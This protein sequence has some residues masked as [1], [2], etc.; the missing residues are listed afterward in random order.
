MDI[1][2]FPKEE[3]FDHVF[4]TT[5]TA[6][7][8]QKIIVGFEIRATQHFH[9][10]KTSVWSF[11]QQHHV[12]M[13]KHNGPLSK[14]DIVTAG[15]AHMLHP[16]FRSHDNL[17]QQ[18]FHSCHPNLDSLPE[19]DD[20]HYDN[21]GMPDIFLSSGR[22]NG[23]CNGSTIRSNVLLIQ[24][25]RSQVKTVCLLLETTFCESDLFEYI[26]VSLKYDNPELFAKMLSLQNEFLDNHRNVAIAG[27]NIR[28]M[29]HT[30][31]YEPYSDESSLWTYLRHIPGVLHLDSCKRTA[32]IGKWNLS[33]TKQDYAQ[34]TEW[35]DEHIQIIFKNLPKDIQ[36]DSTTINF[37][38]PRR[39]S[40]SVRSPHA[41]SVSSGISFNQRL[42]ART[43][44][45]PAV[46]T[47]QRAAWSSPKP[48]S[49]LAYEFNDTEFPPMQNKQA[50]NRSTTV[51]TQMSS[52][53][54]Q[55]IKDSINAKTSKMITASKLHEEQ[56]D[57]HI[58]KIET[59]LASLTSSIVTQ[60]FAKL[61]GH[62]S[63]FVTVLMLDEKLGNLSRQIEKMSRVTSPPSSI[64]D[65]PP[66][67]KARAIGPAD[68]MDIVREPPELCS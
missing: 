12:F 24:V 4:Q 48:I 10:I 60:I 34:V 17:R 30:M 56:I 31:T 44:D 20:K 29:D 19:Y 46:I 6:G 50:N 53:S 66:P 28:A 15:W 25:E 27:L 38:I 39:L 14:M 49:A 26:P 33:T 22:L 7:R 16:T 51:A 23:N 63:P 62:D 65:S 42:A 55:M 64:T 9:A 18:I 36:A 67:Q 54:E 21:K 68:P 2:D 1:G 61:S 59:A 52:I 5:A 35:I 47:I 45:T 43:K 37:P 32:D 11:L 3:D 8:N 40:R 57:N 58:L 41:T 13:K